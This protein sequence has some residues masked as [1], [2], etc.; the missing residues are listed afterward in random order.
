ML[1]YHKNG[2]L[3]LVI[4]IQSGIVRGSLVCLESQEKP[5]LIYI[6]HK[7]IENNG[8]IDGVN[9]MR[10]MVSTLSEVIDLVVREGVGRAKSI[11]FENAKI[12]NIH[13][14]LSSPWIISESKTV[15]IEY[16]QDTEI[17][18]AI[19]KKM[20][21]DEQSSF[22]KKYQ[23]ENIQDEYEFDLSFIE[24]KIFAIRLNGY[25]VQQYKNKKTRKLEV[26]FAV[27]LSSNH[28]LDKIKEATKKIINVKKESYHSAL[29][30]H[31]VSLRSLIPNQ[32]EYVSLHVHGEL[33]DIVIVKKGV[34]SYLASFPFGI[35]TLVRRLS[36]EGKINIESAKS[37]ISMYVDNKLDDAERLR[38]EKIINTI[39]TDWQKECLEIFNKAGE[40]SLVP[41]VI[42]LSLANYMDIFR[43]ILSLTKFEV[44]SFDDSIVDNVVHFEKISERS[45]LMG[46]YAFALNDMI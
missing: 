18:E 15:K 27:T 10:T 11:G 8:K 32:E 41:R 24:Q 23:K 29:L 42:Y 4:D 22:I 33:T 12:D 6:V 19:V 45:P 30:L 28:I 39:V 16:E 3:S 26:S 5:N 7:H 31:Y 36:Q 34:S 38:I 13:Y 2:I 40:N 46:M 37:T 9:M 14:I 43:Q 20:I 17:T 1:S 21:D 25:S 35:M 44:I